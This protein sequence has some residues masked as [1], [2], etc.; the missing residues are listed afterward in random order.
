MSKRRT[1]QFIAARLYGDEALVINTDTMKFLWCH[2]N[3]MDSIKSL[4]NNG[5][6]NIE[7][8]E[9]LKRYIKNGT[10]ILI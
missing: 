9:E 7:N 5:G 4:D 3:A 10:R 2:K 1:K 6:Y 8:L